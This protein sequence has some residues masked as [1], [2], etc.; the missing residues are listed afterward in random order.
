M[1]HVRNVASFEGFVGSCTGF[2]A[3]YNPGS[4]KLQLDAL[5]V[6]LVNARQ[7]LTS[8]H[9]NKTEYDRVTNN[10]EVYFRNIL[11]LA[12]SVILTLDASG[13]K[14]ETLH[15]AR[16]FYRML[17]GKRARVKALDADPVTGE[18]KTAP[19]VA[20]LSYESKTDHFARLVQLVIATPLYKANEPELS[21]QGLKATVKKLHSLNTEVAKARVAL[22]NA[23]L[24]R[25]QQ[26]YTTSE[27][28][29]EVGRAG[30]KY[31]RAVF[32]FNS[33]EYAQVKRLVFTKPHS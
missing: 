20:Q 31:V 28:I 33:E 32:G 26:L 14:A 13:A 12:A 7:A 18:V 2:G 3:K 9:E 19:R 5:N 6:L 10:R 22:S 11:P 25:N 30:R 8:V 1:T 17:L 4:P 16:S 15:D 27:A 29:Y 24:E 21:V 23:R